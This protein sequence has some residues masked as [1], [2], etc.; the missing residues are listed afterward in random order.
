MHQ[1]LSFD[2]TPSSPAGVLDR[3]RPVVW[4]RRT[5]IDGYPWREALP[6]EW[7]AAVV[8]PIAFVVQRDYEAAANSVIGR[9]EENAPCFCAYLYALMELRS[10]DGE[11]LRA[12]A[13]YAEETLSWRLRD[14]RWLLRRSVTVGEDGEA[15]RPFYCLSETMPR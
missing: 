6:K 12:E 3:P 13:A 14:G 10:D 2:G 1:H 11:E 4:R 8:A 15:G 7:Q 9:D 5:E